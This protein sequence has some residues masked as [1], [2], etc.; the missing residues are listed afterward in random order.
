MWLMSGCE[1]DDT[2]EGP[3]DGVPLTSR[4]DSDSNA[5]VLH[6]ALVSRISSLDLFRH[7]GRLF[8]RFK[9]LTDMKFRS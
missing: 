9:T 8:S 6:L 4:D 3:R 7:F 1:Y 5:W 2:G